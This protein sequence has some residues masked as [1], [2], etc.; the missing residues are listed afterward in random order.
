MEANEVKVVT[1]PE[2]AGDDVQEILI[3]DNVGK[4]MHEGYWCYDCNEEVAPDID[5]E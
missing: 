1:C 3:P 4:G 5:D 2:C